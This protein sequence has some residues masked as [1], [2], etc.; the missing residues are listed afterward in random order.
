MTDPY[1]RNLEFYGKI[2]GNYHVAI[3]D[4]GL[5]VL[6]A[7][8]PKHTQFIQRI[9]VE[10]TTLA[11]SELWTFQDSA[12]VVLVPA[13]SAGA[14]AHFDFDFGP[15]GVPCTES[16]AFMVN[17]TGATGASGWTTWEGYKKLTNAAP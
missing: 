1:Q 9:H 13:I 2:S 5:I 14:I 4:T 7:A 16:A 10:V 15:E 12:S 8:I 6:V 3:T 11:A 17:I